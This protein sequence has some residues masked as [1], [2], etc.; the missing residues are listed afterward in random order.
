MEMDSDVLMF[1]SSLSQIKIDMYK[2]REMESFE[3]G[4]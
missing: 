4:L 3:L 2:V 1:Q